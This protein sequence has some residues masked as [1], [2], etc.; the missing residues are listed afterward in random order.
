[1]GGH[2]SRNGGSISTLLQQG[3]RGWVEKTFGLILASVLK[4][5]HVGFALSI[6]DNSVESHSLGMYK[7]L[8]LI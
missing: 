1:M 6:L 4:I 2:L 7:G 5:Q 8:I 3:Q